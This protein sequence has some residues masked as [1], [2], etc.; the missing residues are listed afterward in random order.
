MVVA[1]TAREQIVAVVSVQ[2]VRPGIAGHH[3]VKC[4]AGGVLEPRRIDGAIGTYR[5]G[6]ALKC[7]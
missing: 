1:A 2:I 6:R 3:V 5:L 7:Q 4:G